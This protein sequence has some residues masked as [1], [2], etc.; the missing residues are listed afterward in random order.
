M[1][2][3]AVR[4]L[5][6]ATRMCTYFWAY[7]Q[8]TRQ[9]HTFTHLPWR[10]SVWQQHSSL[11]SHPTSP[12]PLGKEREWPREKKRNQVGRNI[13]ENRLFK[14]NTSQRKHKSAAHMVKRFQA[15][16]NTFLL[17]TLKPITGKLFLLSTSEGLLIKSLAISSC[18]EAVG[19]CNLIW[20]RSRASRC[21]DT[22][23]LTS[24]VKNGYQ[25]Q[26]WAM[27]RNICSAIQKGVQACVLPFNGEFIF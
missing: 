24:S 26:L 25:T 5:S 9:T 8:R 1:I 12:R 11:L 18:Y 10:E 19:Y 27:G 16:R 21:D 6:S 2:L 7:Q 4:S 3:W 15:L 20:T 14:A 22:V 13:R 17:S 23:V